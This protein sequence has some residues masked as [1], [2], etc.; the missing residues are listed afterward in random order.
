MTSIS[1]RIL[2]DGGFGIFVD[3]GHDGTRKNFSLRAYKKHQVVSPLEQL[4]ECDVTADVDFGYLKS[5][6]S[7]RSLVFGPVT[8]RLVF[9]S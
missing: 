3:Y 7:P 4:G 8:Q 2:S 9:Y 1:E 5:L 6:V